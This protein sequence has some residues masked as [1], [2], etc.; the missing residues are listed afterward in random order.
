MIF[1]KVRFVVELVM[2]F[3]ETELHLKQPLSLL[4]MLLYCE[5][6][7]LPLRETSVCCINK[8]FDSVAFF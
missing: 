5:P 7:E 8:S 6:S 3:R 1:F 4:L 2:Q